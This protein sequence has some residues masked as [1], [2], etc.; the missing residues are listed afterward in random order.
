MTEEIKAVEAQTLQLNKNYN[1]R[2][3]SI[4][5]KLCFLETLEVE[6]ILVESLNTIFD[7]FM[8][9]LQFILLSSANNLPQNRILR[10]LKK[11]CRKA[12]SDI[13][14]NDSDTRLAK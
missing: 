8:I 11:L 1:S 4:A 7:D 10:N 2:F 5:S 9:E 13:F 14:D 3:E 6:E 12:N